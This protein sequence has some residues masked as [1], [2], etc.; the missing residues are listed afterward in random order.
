MK[1]FPLKDARPSGAPV[2]PRQAIPIGL[3]VTE[4]FRDANNHGEW[5]MLEDAL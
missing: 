3:D 1:I 5:I 4:E 2:G